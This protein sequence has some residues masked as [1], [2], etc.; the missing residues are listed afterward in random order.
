MNQLLTTP[1]AAALLRVNPQ[2]LYRWRRRG[3]GPDYTTVGRKV[4]YETAVLEA[5]L[6]GQRRQ[7]N[8]GKPA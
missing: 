4:F 3:G 2:T 6:T 5:W 1:E 7:S 8:H